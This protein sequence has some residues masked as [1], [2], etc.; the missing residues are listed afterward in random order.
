MHNHARSPQNATS[1]VDA[2]QRD[3]HALGVQGTEVVAHIEVNEVRLG[4]LLSDKDSRRLEP[5]ARIVVPRDRAH[6]ALKR[7]RLDE[8]V[9]APVEHADFLQHLDAWPVP[10]RSRGRGTGALSTRAN[11]RDRRALRAPVGGSLALW[12][13]L[14]AAYGGWRGGALCDAGARIGGHAG[15]SI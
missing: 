7:N 11:R 8:Q 3:R 2:L 6:E 15:S 9:R 13:G 5:Q 4:R 1:Q 14:S 12:N 10:A